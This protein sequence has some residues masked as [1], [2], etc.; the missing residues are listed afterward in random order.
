MIFLLQYERKSRRLVRLRTFDNWEAA[1]K[2]RLDLE[3]RLNRDRPAND[4]NEVVLLEAT[5]EQALRQ[6]HA[7]YFDSISDLAEAMKA[8]AS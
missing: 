5:N 2:A 1:D 3:L 8:A 7:R 4:V 6:T